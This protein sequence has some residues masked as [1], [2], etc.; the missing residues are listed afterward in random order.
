MF[1]Q[2]LKSTKSKPFK[3]RV[4]NAKSTRTAFEFNASRPFALVFG[5]AFAV[6][7]PLLAIFPIL[8]GCSSFPSEPKPEVS[9]GTY[10][11]DAPNPLFVQTNDADYLWNAAVDVVDNYFEIEYESPIRV[12]D[13]QTASGQ[14]YSAS[15]EGRIDTKPTIAAGVLEPWRKNSIGCE[16]RWEATFQTIRRKAVVRVVPDGSGFLVYLA[17]YNEIED[18]PRPLG[19]TVAVNFEFTDDL[20]QIEQASGGSVKSKGWIPIGRDQELETRMLQEIAWRLG[21]PPTILHSP[22]Q[23]T[24]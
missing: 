15:T 14:A 17:V 21:N 6:G 24:P 11:T 9:V 22:T 10:Q 2:S 18:L 13:K 3:R 5:G 1:F 7:A 4:R 19:S 23:L 16:K 20:T 8:P 12:F